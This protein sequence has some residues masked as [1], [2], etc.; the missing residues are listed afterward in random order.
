MLAIALDKV[1]EDLVDISRKAGNEILDVYKDSFEITLKEDLS[2]LTDAD[3]RSNEVIISKLKSIYP[4][5]PILSEEEKEV[6]FSARKSWEMFWLIDPLDGTKEFVKR[7]GEFTVNIALIK[8]Q[9]PIAGV[10]Y[11]PTK[12]IFWYG[13]ENIGSYKLEEGSKAKRIE[14]NQSTDSPVKV[15]TSRSHP[16]AKLESYLKRFS[17]YEIVHMGSSLKICLVADGTAHVYPRLGPTMEWDSGAGHAVLKFAGGEL[18][19]TETSVE[20]KYN[21]EILRN[22][23]F[24]CFTPKIREICEIL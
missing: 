13:A 10:V 9:L 8:N 19:D 15:V 5:I 17:E 2:P 20:L 7:N 14:V 11:A 3:K 16:S 21:K 24:I 22:P 12:N 4:G 1:L 18:L 23:D 6:Q